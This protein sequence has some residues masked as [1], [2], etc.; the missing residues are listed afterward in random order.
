MAKTERAAWGPDRPSESTGILGHLR[1]RVY[2]EGASW[3]ATVNDALV[4]AGTGASPAFD[5]R[6]AARDG[7]ESV[8]R[9]TLRGL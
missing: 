5:S 6:E 9:R 3:R 4:V 8:A 7:S 2:R 1:L